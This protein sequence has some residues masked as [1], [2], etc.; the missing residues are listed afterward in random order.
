MILRFDG[1]HVRIGGKRDCK[2]GQICVQRKE[3]SQ[4]L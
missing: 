4:E 1:I 3:G 2:R